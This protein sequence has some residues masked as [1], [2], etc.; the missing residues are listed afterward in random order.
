MRP[1]TQRARPRPAIERLNAGDAPDHRRHAAPA[2][3]SEPRAFRPGE[4]D[5]IRVR[6]E[7]PD[8]EAAI[9]V[10][11]ERA[12]PTAVE[13]DLVDAL[14]VACSDALSLVAEADGRI[15]GHIL[16]SPV[17]IEGAHGD[18]IGMGLAPMAI[19]PERQRQGIGAA[20]VRDGLRRLH[21]RGCP[22]VI[23]LGHPDYYPRFGFER[24]SLYGITSQWDGIPDEALLVLF[25]ARPREGDFAG[26][27][28]YRHEFDAAM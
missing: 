24:A 7:R 13:A 5:V 17:R 4:A 23:V 25:P 9:R 6:E 8:D 14:R 12:F 27:A 28:R 21:E 3:V 15:V 18:R 2:V 20:L 11:N 19:L 1:P 16:F 10:V 26:T 22:F